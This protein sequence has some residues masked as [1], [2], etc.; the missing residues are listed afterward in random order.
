M[1]TSFMVEQFSGVCSV[2]ST[3]YFEQG[4]EEYQ[5]YDFI[6]MPSTV[7]LSWYEDLETGLAFPQTSWDSGFAWMAKQAPKVTVA[8]I[9]IVY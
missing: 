1:F 2:I 4:I 8:G 9:Q 6:C 7:F 5:V 3:K